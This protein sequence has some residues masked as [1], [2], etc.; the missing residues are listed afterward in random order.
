M[1]V[2]IAIRVSIRRTAAEL[3]EELVHHAKPGTHL[4]FVTAHPAL[5]AAL[6]SQLLASPALAILTAV[7][8]SETTAEVAYHA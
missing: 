5:E 4:A 7:A 1:R 3:L 2:M 6:E 8:A